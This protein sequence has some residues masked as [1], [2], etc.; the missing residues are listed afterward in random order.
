MR[1]RPEDGAATDMDGGGRSTLARFKWRS[2]HRSSDRRCRGCR[3]GPK[4]TS[5]SSGS[6]QAQ[7]R[8][9]ELELLEGEG[10]VALT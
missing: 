3:F 6:R 4:Q 7:A 10:N 8:R 2:E 1:R 9:L 5:R